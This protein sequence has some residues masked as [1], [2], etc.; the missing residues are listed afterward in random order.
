ME[1]FSG[2]ALTTTTM[3]CTSR[4]TT[5]LGNLMYFSAR[6]LT[7]TLNLLTPSVTLNTVTLAKSTNLLGN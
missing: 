6:W 2:D 1:G 7:I 5:N 4:T 3:T